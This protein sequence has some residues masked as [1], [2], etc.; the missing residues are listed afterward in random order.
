MNGAAGMNDVMNKTLKHARVVVV[1][2][3]GVTAIVIGIA[4]LVL[5]GPGIVV[6]IAG[7]AIL[8]TEFVWARRLMRK[9]KRAARSVKESMQGSGKKTSETRAP[10]DVNCPKKGE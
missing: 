10:S 6:I 5:P 2:V 8:G 7:L 1:A 3:L 4:M 9:V